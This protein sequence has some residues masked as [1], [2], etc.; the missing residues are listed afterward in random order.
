MRNFIVAAALVAAGTSF[1]S[2]TARLGDDWIRIFDS[3]CVSAETMMRIPPAM[4][5][6]FRKVQARIGGQTFFG[7]YVFRN[8]AVYVIY[9]DGDQ[10]VI[11]LSAFKLD[12]E[13]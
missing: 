1:A 7:C 4:R 12:P 10:G 11:P 13:A 3:P 5:D 2:Q 9:D 8:D 6:Q